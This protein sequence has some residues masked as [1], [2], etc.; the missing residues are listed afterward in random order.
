MIKL[1]LYTA[2]TVLSLIALGYLAIFAIVPIAFLVL[3]LSN[4][5]PKIQHEN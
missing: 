5:R 3:L 4:H 1:L 2:A